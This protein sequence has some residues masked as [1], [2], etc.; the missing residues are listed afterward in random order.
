MSYP[1]IKSFLFLCGEWSSL[2]FK[3]FQKYF[4]KPNVFFFSLLQ[5]FWRLFI[6][7]VCYVIKSLLHERF[8]A[9][10][11]TS[12]SNSSMFIMS[13]AEVRS[14]LAIIVYLFVSKALAISD[15]SSSPA[16]LVLAFNY[17]SAIPCNDIIACLCLFLFL[18]SFLS[19][20]SLSFLL[21]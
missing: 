14:R 1:Y 6:I 11:T 18:L 10:V 2:V 19:L 17:N 4:F 8:E 13:N 3:D 7:V 15:W 9:A 12:F 16:V 20:S 5:L 21:S